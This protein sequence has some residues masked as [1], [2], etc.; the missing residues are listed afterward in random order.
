MTTAEQGPVA[1]PHRYGAPVTSTRPALT[2][3][4]AAL[5]LVGCAGPLPGSASPAPGA[6]STEATSAPQ[7]DVPTRLAQAGISADLIR[8]TDLDGF[9]LATQSVGVSGDEGM[10]AAYF[11]ADDGG[12]VMLRT[13]RDA[14]EGVAPCDGL[15]GDVTVC[16]VEH[17]GA[18][19][20]FEGDGVDAATL[21]EAAAALRVPGADE[22]EALFADLPAVEEPVERGDLPEGD[23]APIDPPH[24][25]G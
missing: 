15:T 10:S 24:I 18:F 22:L 3:T 23:G 1:R 4:V 17:Q 14:P 8:V 2:L 20:T 7:V 12:T 6:A 16:V 11:N 5:L 19:V 25:G 9:T 21:S 13:S